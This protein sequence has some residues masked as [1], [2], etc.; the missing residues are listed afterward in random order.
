MSQERKLCDQRYG[1][2][3]RLLIS[4]TYIHM[5]TNTHTHTNIHKHIIKTLSR[6]PI[7]D[8]I[9]QHVKTGVFTVC[10]K[11]VYVHLM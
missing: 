7:K 1:Y 9:G 5:H 6:S 10:V 2:T 3:T 11:V 8:K 4:V